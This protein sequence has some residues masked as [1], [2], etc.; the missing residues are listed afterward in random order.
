MLVCVWLRSTEW[1]LNQPHGPVSPVTKTS[2]YLS[3][4][5]MGNAVGCLRCFFFGVASVLVFASINFG[6]SALGFGAKG[7]IASMSW[8]T[9]RQASPWHSHAILAD[10]ESWAS[11]YQS[12]HYGG[13]TPAAGWFAKL[14][15][16]GMTGGN[17]LAGMVGSIIAMVFSCFTSR[18]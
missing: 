17:L 15:S 2:T 1:L 9:T 18:R 8:F 12:A 5:N 7:I 14:T 16:I 11:A 10:T 6:I 13:F 3:R 4:D